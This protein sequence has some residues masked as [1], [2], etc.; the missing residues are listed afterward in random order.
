MADPLGPIRVIRAFKPSYSCQKHRIRVKTPEFSNS[1]IGVT[2]STPEQA[3][4]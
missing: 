2:V 1:A 3:R 4:V